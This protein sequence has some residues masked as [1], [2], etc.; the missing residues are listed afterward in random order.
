VSIEEALPIAGLVL[1]IGAWT[2]S[3]RGSALRL[4]LGVL[5][6][7][8]AVRLYTAHDALLDQVMDAVVAF[9]RAIL[10]WFSTLSA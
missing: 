8:I 4:F 5:L 1:L 9:P 10:D 2:F 7:V 6:I 3:R